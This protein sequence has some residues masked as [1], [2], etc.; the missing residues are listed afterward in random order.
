M[1]NAKPAIILL[2]SWLTLSLVFGLHPLLAV[3]THAM[4]VHSTLAEGLQ[5]SKMWHIFTLHR[6]PPMLMRLYTKF[7]Y[8]YVKIA[9]LGNNVLTI[10]VLTNNVLTINVITNHVLSYT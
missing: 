6:G 3:Q 5:E 1:H 7:S 8:A 4:H 9:V 2:C 10:N